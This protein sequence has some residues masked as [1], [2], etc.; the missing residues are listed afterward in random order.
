MGYF[1]NN[2][3]YLLFAL[4]FEPNLDH[5]LFIHETQTLFCIK[6]YFKKRVTS[7]INGTGFFNELMHMEN[8]I[9]KH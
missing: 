5:S 1:L 9:K 7:P 6:M 4:A 3:E 2:F 8:I